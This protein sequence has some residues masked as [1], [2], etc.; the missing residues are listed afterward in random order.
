[1]GVC[2]L[3]ALAQGCSRPR[4]D[5]RQSATENPSAPA[6][7]AGARDST[8]RVKGSNTML[9]LTQ[10]WATAYQKAVPGTKVSV[11]GQ[12]TATGFQ[13]LAEG[14][15]EVANASRKIN[16]DEL[17]LCKF[18]GVEPEEHVVGYDGIV[19]IVNRANP[20][21]KLSVDQLSDLYTGKTTT[22][23]ALGGSGDV[24]LLSRNRNSGTYALFK[25]H[26]ILKGQPG[27]ADYSPSTVMLETTAQIRSEV[28]KS[29]GAIGYIG[30]GYL[31][32]SVKGVPVV[33][34]RGRAM[35]ATSSSVRDGSYP[36]ARPL[37][38]YVRKDATP[39]VRRYLDWLTGADAQ[40]IIARREFAALH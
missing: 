10:D 31:D 4:S 33:D 40:R 8:I 17:Q 1:M 27:T 16:A 34:K 22:W 15:A 38:V 18:W 9:E 7:A 24:T 29:P 30:L 25:E 37:L 36:I 20:L 6:I 39:A 26:V 2:L 19:V 35:M 32:A 5:L 28:A 23:E 13:A 12:G 3:A 14:T 11:E 21:G